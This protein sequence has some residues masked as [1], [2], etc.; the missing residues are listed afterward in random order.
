MVREEDLHDDVDVHE[1]RLWV[2]AAGE[3]A[4]TDD[5]DAKTVKTTPAAVE[6]GAMVMI[7]WCLIKAQ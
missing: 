6:S 3:N 2:G 5:D 7:Y 4:T 1:M